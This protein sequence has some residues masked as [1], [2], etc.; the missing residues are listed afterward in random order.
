MPGVRDREFVSKRL[1]NSVVLVDAIAAKADGDHLSRRVIVVAAD[2]IVAAYDLIGQPRSRE[3]IER[4][5][6]KRADPNTER[7]PAI[8]GRSEMRLRITTVLAPQ[9]TKGFALLSPS[10]R[11]LLTND[12]ARERRR[13]VASCHLRPR[14]PRSCKPRPAGPT[15]RRARCPAR[16][17][18]R[19][20][21]RRDLRR[22]VGGCPGGAGRDCPDCSPTP[23]HTS[24]WW[25]STVTDRSRPTGTN[26]ARFS[27]T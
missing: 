12:T 6:P 20:A 5:C 22:P 9:L 17:T 2:E 13:H 19:L 18:A 27:A 11:G 14:S 4:S 26:L 10:C 16:P 3:G 15:G 25:S 1:R 24:T 7:E 23:P 8:P 21:A